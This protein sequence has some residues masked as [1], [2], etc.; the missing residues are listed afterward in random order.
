MH[1]EGKGQSCHENVLWRP[2]R[3]RVFLVQDIWRLEGLPGEADHMHP[4][5]LSWIYRGSCHLTI[6][7]TLKTVFRLMSTP[8]M[9]MSVE[10]C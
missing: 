8:Q 7:D 5:A 6:L 9:K 4:P 2:G 3:G 1:S 10:T